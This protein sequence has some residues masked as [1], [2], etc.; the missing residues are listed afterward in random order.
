MTEPKNAEIAK[1]NT[2]ACMVFLW[3]QDLERDF[4]SRERLAAPKVSDGFVVC[5]DS[6]SYYEIGRKI[7]TRYI[8]V[9]MLGLIDI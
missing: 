6:I 8:A 7:A 9:P 3:Y 1:I 4:E 5:C 2:V